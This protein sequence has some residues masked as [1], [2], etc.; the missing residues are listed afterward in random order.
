MSSF[1]NPSTV[2]MQTARP[3]S[4]K[5]LMVVLI[6]VLVLILVAAGSAVAYAKFDMF[7]SP[8]TLYLQA[9]MNNLSSA[10]ESLQ[11]VKKQYEAEVLPLLDKPLHSVVDISDVTID[12]A[13]P[14]AE[15]SKVME[16]IKKIKLGFDV[17]QNA[18]TNQ[19]LTKI[20]LAV[21]ADPF[22][23]LE[24][25][26]DPEKMALRVP[27]LYAKYLYV[28][29]KDLDALKN[30]MGTNNLPK[31]VLS[32]NDL[33]NA[34]YIKEE[35]LTAVFMPYGKLY[36]DNIDPNQVTMNKNGVLEEENTRIEATEVIVTFNQADIKRLTSSFVE[37]LLADTVLQDLVYTRTKNVALLLNDSGY[38]TQEPS[39]EEFLAYW[40][41]SVED[42]KISA[43]KGNIADGA[44]MTLYVD[45]NHKIL[46]RKFA[47]TAKNESGQNNAMLIKAAGWK[48]AA[49]VNQTLFFVS[50]K[51]DKGEGGEMKIV[52]ASNVGN[53]G[54]KG[55]F[56]MDVKPYGTSA[57]NQAF[58]ANVD[59]DLQKSDT[60]E[61]GIFNFNITV[62]GT[63]KDAGAI[64]GSMNIDTT[65]TGTA[66][67]SN[68]DVKLNFT[69]VQGQ[70]EVKG[71]SFK[72]HTKQETITEVKMPVMTA[73]NSIDASKLTDQ[74]RLQLLQEVG[75]NAQN[76]MAKNSAL[77]GAFGVPTSPMMPPSG[78][79]PNLEIPDDVF[80]GMTP[81]E[82]AEMQQLIEQMQKAQSMQ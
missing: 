29:T 66:K 1:E 73:D 10:K 71:I 45:G 75:I 54:G 4:K 19:T 43:D 82:K 77:L 35:E 65:K 20:S 7:K 9:E 11:A 31:K 14:N 6:I 32:Y 72:L 69:N 79:M 81:A 47:F 80:E 22:I 59:Y 70:S 56:V 36:A 3:R 61:A 60:K 2:G 51:D 21:G 38:P 40:K 62:P 24:A 67:D 25:A 74:Q 39:K 33:V 44:T 18:K 28:N 42:M 16:T 57:A 17:E 49:A 13:S 15:L 58:L 46:E 63:S 26:I 5:P 78:A 48:D 30:E 27:E 52:N 12:L 50:S 37:Q 41:K 64:K 53:S 68:V 34:V 8:K 55:K 23:N 76:F